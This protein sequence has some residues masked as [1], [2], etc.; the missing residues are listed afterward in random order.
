MAT[1]AL[2]TVDQVTGRKGVVISETPHSARAALEVLQRGGNAVDAL[3]CAG[4][5]DAVCRPEMNG[6]FAW[7][8]GMVFYFA[9][10][11]RAVAVPMSAFTPMATR[12]DM[13]EL[14][15]GP[16]GYSVLG[17]PGP[18]LSKLVHSP[19]GMVKDDL[20]CTGYLAVV[21]PL[22]LR[23]Y[24]V[25]SEHFGRMPMAE[26][27]QPAIRLAEEGFPVDWLLRKC[28]TKAASVIQSRFPASADLLTPN[29]RVPEVGETFRNPD[30]GRTLRA[31]AQEGVD[32]FYTGWL[33]RT[34]VDDIRSNGG[35]L[36]M[37]DLARARASV[38]PE[39]AVSAPYRDYLF[40]TPDLGSS[41][42]TT[43][44]QILKLLE[45]FDLSGLGPSH[46][47]YL[48]LLI[49]A[50]KVVWAKRFETVGDPNTMPIPQQELLSS[51]YLDGLGEQLRLALEGKARAPSGAGSPGVPNT[52]HL[53][54][55]DGE[56]NLASMTLSHS[57]EFGSLATVPGTGIILNGGM[58]ALDPHPGLP[59]SLGPWK[60]PAQRMSPMVA[61]RMGKPALAIGATG[62]RR[63]ISVL[64]QVLVNLVDFRLSPDAALL[65]PRLH[66]EASEPVWI[67]HGGVEEYVPNVSGYRGDVVLE[68]RHPEW[69]FTDDVID[70]LAA[71]GHT[72]ERINA[73]IGGC[74]VATVDADG[75]MHG[76]TEPRKRGFSTAA[77]F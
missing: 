65:T 76:F 62:A 29:G 61:T 2:A 59:N 16:E 33:A 67:E 22:V 14:V 17:L 15:S 35:I 3:V 25:A 23:A 50:L 28:I 73:M 20:N 63:I 57:T 27:L 41:G 48:H 69:G 39:E 1:E 32:V 40:Y 53:L 44:L 26:L 7:G 56:G 24:Q 38:R 66:V 49:E 19:D 74:V 54:V 45:P 30:L 12:T 4:L 72:F 60:R 71:R 51:V 68:G 34:I 8:G 64:A 55:V 42:G 9:R 5:T 43:V 6:I 70:A 10:T 31:I 36:S 47:E 46:P 58:H 52:E 18:N 21:V 37:E 77:A 11:G 13:Y 75:L